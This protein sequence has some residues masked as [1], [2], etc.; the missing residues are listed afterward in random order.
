MGIMNEGTLKFLIGAG[1]PN[2]AIGQI[3]HH[4]RDWKFILAWYLVAK[5]AGGGRKNFLGPEQ[6]FQVQAPQTEL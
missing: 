3:F 1:I 6:F 2:R 5:E 4:A